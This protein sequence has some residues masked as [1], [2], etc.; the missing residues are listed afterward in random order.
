MPPLFSPPDGGDVRGGYLDSSLVAAFASLGSLWFPMVRLGRLAGHGYTKQ[1]QPAS[2][3]ESS[4]L[5]KFLTV[6][7]FD[8]TLFIPIA[9]PLSSLPRDGGDVRGGYL[10]S[11]LVAAFASLGSLWFP[12]V[13]LGRLAGHGYTKQLQPASRDESSGLRKFLTV[14]S[15]PLFSPPRRGRCKR[16][17]RRPRVYG[18]SSKSLPNPFTRCL[19]CSR[20]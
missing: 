16:G 3:D 18:I 1:L 17:S 7:S 5:R 2:R 12:V 19:T 20:F 8:E 10:D 9:C 4:G 11:S 13:R 14:L 6:L 15:P